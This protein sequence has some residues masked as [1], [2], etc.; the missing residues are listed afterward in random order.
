[1]ESLE[2]IFT[3]AEQARIPAEIFHLKTSNRAN[4]GKMP[5]VLKKNRSSA[6]VRS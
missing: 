1:M 2:E 3:I 4:W 5:E 6:G